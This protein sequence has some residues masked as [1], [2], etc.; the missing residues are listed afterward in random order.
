[1]DRPEDDVHVACGIILVLEQRV[2]VVEVELDDAV[3]ELGGGLKEVGPIEVVLI[4]VL[5]F[6]FAG[7]EGVEDGIVEH[8]HESHPAIILG[9]ALT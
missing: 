5:D 2:V 7:F 9:I 4:F 8:V 3:L 1:M 6:D